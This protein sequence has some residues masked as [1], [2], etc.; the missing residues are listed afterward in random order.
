MS[1]FSD[2]HSEGA[3]VGHVNVKALMDGIKSACKFQD[4][5]PAQ[6]SAINTTCNLV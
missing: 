1:S 2:A 3:S 4:L 6:L 5:F